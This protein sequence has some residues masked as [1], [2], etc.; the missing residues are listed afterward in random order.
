MKRIISIITVILM[1]GSSNVVA[2]DS[3][4]SNDNSV[5]E[6]TVRY[7]YAITTDDKEWADFTTKQEKVDATRIPIDVLTQ[8][9]TAQLVDAV[10]DYPLIVVLY[11]YNTFEQG[12]KALAKDSDAFRELLK[13]PDAGA[14]LLEKLLLA[15]NSES[16]TRLQELTINTI[17]ILLTEETIWSS[18]QDE[19]FELLSDQSTFLYTP[20]GTMV[21]AFMNAELDPVYLAFLNGLYTFSH[22]DAIPISGSTNRYNCHSY[23]WYWQSTY[24]EYWIPIADSYVTDGSY[25]LRTNYTNVPVGTRVYY[26]DG[27]HTAYVSEVTPGTHSSPSTLIVTSK[28]GPGPLMRHTAG[29]SPYSS[30]GL[31]LWE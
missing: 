13:R 1:L 5:V 22:P 26:P 12:L 2:F 16:E 14:V 27:E 25:S 17:S 11:A 30:S 29:D 21:L 28:W 31:T 10:I 4:N 23:A 9:N 20:N 24:N 3:L 19:D 18:L 15:K 6:E 8:L 7:T